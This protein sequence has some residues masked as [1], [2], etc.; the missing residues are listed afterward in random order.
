MTLTKEQQQEFEQA[1]IPL[2]KWLNNNCHPH[3]HIVVEDDGA[4]LH[5]GVLRIVNADFIRD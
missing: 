4:E 3:T 5:E 1:A 2:I